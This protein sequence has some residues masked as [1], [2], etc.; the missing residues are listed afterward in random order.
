MT[1]QINKIIHEFDEN[2]NHRLIVS[3]DPGLWVPF[4]SVAQHI[5]FF[6]VTSFFE[7]S[8]LPEVFDAVEVESRV[9]PASGRAE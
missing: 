6:A 8:D 4:N 3:G 1:E 7:G 2:Q 5:G 9:L